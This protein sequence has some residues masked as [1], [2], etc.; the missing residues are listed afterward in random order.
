MNSFSKPFGYK[1][2]T[3]SA[4]EKERKAATGGVGIM[5]G[6]KA[7]DHLISVER[8]SDRILKAQFRGNPAMTVLVAYAPIEATE[9]ECKDTF[10][11]QLRIAIESVA[12]HN[13]LAVF[14]DANA[15]LGPDDNG[16]RLLEIL[17]EYQLLAANTLFQKR[18]GKLWTW[19]SPQEAL[20]QIDYILVRS[21][22]R[23]S[24]TNCEAY[25]F[26][27]SLYSDHRVVTAEVSLKLRKTKPASIRE[28]KYI[29][30]DLACDES[31]QERYAVEVRNR[32]EALKHEDTDESSTD[33]DKFVTSSAEA[34]EK[35][36]RKV[37]R[38]KKKVKFLDPRVAKV[39]KMW[40]RLLRPT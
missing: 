25:G 3:V 27:S 17:E 16:Q 38:Q 37:P 35:C 36:L 14:T 2:Y 31:L 4:W 23:S 9:A 39:E 22:W 10:Y 28:P 15:R 34:A 6:R 8:L 21:K 33:Y 29:S 32:Y 19:R 24:V 20:H 18:K 12:P 40:K 1:F 11:S 13:F 26:F 30:S 5:L 7:Q